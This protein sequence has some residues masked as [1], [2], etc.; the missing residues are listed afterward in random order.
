METGDKHDP[1]QP[2]AAAAEES[3]AALGGEEI[4]EPSLL[5]GVTQGQE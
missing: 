1:Q 3:P 5:E 2:V 4:P